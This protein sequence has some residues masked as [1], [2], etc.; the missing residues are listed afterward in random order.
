MTCRISAPQ[1]RIS[2][3][4]FHFVNSGWVERFLLIFLLLFIYG[5][6]DM[7][8]LF[9]NEFSSPELLDDMCSHQ[10]NEECTKLWCCALKHLFWYQIYNT[11]N[12]FLVQKNYA[13]YNFL[14]P[15]I[16]YMFLLS[17]AQYIVFW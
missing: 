7:E 6:D 11:Q 16:Q 2:N 8:D 3:A 9:L 13:L 10:I 5:L 17:N 15:N 4:Y 12:Y 1:F 14:V